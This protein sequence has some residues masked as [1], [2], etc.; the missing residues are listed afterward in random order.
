MLENIGLFLDILGCACICVCGFGIIYC[1]DTSVCRWA[2]CSVIYCVLGI[3][4]L[5]VFISTVNIIVGIIMLEYSLSL[6]S[7]FRVPVH[8][9]HVN[10]VLTYSAIMCNPTFSEIHR[11]RSHNGPYSLMITSFRFTSSFVNRPTV[12]DNL[13]GSKNVLLLHCGFSKAKR[14]K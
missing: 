9:K 4:F 2:K 10:Q 14:N 8:A 11:E 6:F 13:A 1:I 12:T 3:S 7:L 5:C